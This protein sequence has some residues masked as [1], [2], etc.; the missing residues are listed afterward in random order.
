MRSCPSALVLSVSAA[1]TPG[2]GMLHLC[3]SA[4][5]HGLVCV[6]SGQLLSSGGWDDLG[7][8]SRSPPS[9]VARQCDLVYTDSTGISKLCAAPKVRF[10][11]LCYTP[12]AFG[13]R[14]HRGWSVHKGLASLFTHHLHHIMLC[15]QFPASS[16]SSC[17]HA[18]GFLTCVQ[19]R[20]FILL[21]CFRSWRRQWHLRFLTHTCNAKV[22]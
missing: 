4:G 9:S 8:T 22:R 2:V 19:T 7:R 5:V 6:Y 15:R 20:C 1:S 18:P 13:G 12:S 10:L 16:L 14:F 17:L 21:G 3:V 11:A